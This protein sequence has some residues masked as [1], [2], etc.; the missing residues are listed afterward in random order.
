M[1]KKEKS[2]VWVYTLNDILGNQEY[3]THAQSQMFAQKTTA[4]S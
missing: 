2:C 4:R 1:K 3:N